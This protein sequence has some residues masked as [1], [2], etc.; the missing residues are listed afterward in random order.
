MDARSGAER[1]LEGIRLTTQS[2]RMWGFSLA[3]WLPHAIANTGVTVVPGD[4]DRM[5]RFLNEQ[6][7]LFTEEWHGSSPSR[8]V[9]ERKAHYLVHD[10]DLV[11]LRNGDDT[12]GVLIGAPEDWSTYYVRTFA[13]RRDFQSPAVVRRFVRECLFRP[14]AERN[15]ERICADT[16]PCNVAMSRLF[17]EL[18][19]LATGSSLSDRWGPLVRY[20]LFLSND[21]EAEFRRKFGAGAPA[22]SPRKSKEDAL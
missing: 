19:F 12:V 6:Y 8:V 15:I 5:G 13:M 18:N 11:E 21:C 22:A 1:R 20:T 2:C 10:C 3:D 7:S 4:F 9:T 14:L 16:S 17:S